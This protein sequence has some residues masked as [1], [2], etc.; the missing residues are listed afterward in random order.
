MDFRMKKSRL[1]QVVLLFVIAVLALSAC[2]P[3]DKA[4]I[5]DATSQSATPISSLEPVIN[6]TTPTS[7]QPYQPQVITVTDGDADK[8][9]QLNVGDLL[10][11]TLE[12]NP[13]TGY[14]WEV[15]PDLNAVVV[16]VGDAEF[17]ADS[18]LM[19]APGKL[20]FTLTA[21]KPGQQMLSLVYRRPF[22]KDVPPTKVFTLD[23]Y[24]SSPTS[25]QVETPMITT[26]QSATQTMVVNPP[27][28]WKGW[29]T[30]TNT[31]Y[32]FSFQ[33]PE[34]WRLVEVTGDD[35]TMSGHAVQ[36]FPD[37]ENDVMFQVAFKNAD[38]DQFIGRTGVGA[39]ELINNGLVSFLGLFLTREVLVFQGK[40]M[41]VMYVYPGTNQQEILFNISL[42]YL[43]SSSTPVGLS[44]GV[45][46]NADNIVASMKI[47]DQ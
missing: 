35:N 29:L 23:V 12:G 1:S 31:A 43:G 25:S 17:K 41:T 26:T 15:Q 32:G 16:Q 30:Y 22:E 20:T 37:S 40:D 28:G 24:V 6:P 9:I 27:N 19:G 33:Y 18:D 42:D 38:E 34:N 44:Q 14:A 21:S 4:Q 47:I 3:S 39:G 7:P 36:L 8:V 11:V 2:T 10:M 13:S 45:E 5:Q 46:S